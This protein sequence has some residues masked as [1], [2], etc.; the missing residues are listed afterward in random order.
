MFNHREYAK[1]T[2]KQIERAQKKSTK[3]KQKYLKTGNINRVGAFEENFSQANSSH[4]S[5]EIDQIMNSKQTVAAIN[6]TSETFNR[7]KSNLY[8]HI[9]AFNP[10]V[11]KMKVGSEY[12][13]SAKNTLNP[14]ESNDANFFELKNSEKKEK[15][16]ESSKHKQTTSLK[17]MENA[18]IIDKNTCETII[19]TE[20]CLNRLP[21][22][23]KQNQN[24]SLSVGSFL[25]M[26][27]IKSFPKCNVPETLNRVLEPNEST[28]YFDQYDEIEAIEAATTA[29]KAPKIIDL[30]VKNQQNTPLNHSD[31]K[32]K[33]TKSINNETEYFLRTRS[34][35]ADPGVIGPI[36][37]QFHQKKLQDEG[38]I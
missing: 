31:S 6:D 14:N 29:S 21:N 8:E 27:S 20:H 24:D 5:S 26:A 13:V 23:D 22:E 10:L 35:G 4:S 16:S 9:E 33:A 28:A 25:S 1:I 38:K 18:K 36:A 12:I 19:N 17:T 11:R 2:K 7:K 3:H 37:W 30:K 34:D 15:S 32:T